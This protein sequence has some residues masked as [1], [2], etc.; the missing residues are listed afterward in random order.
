MID[1]TAAADTVQDRISVSNRQRCMDATADTDTPTDRRNVR[2]YLLESETV[3]EWRGLL[4][5]H[6]TSDRSAWPPPVDLHRLI[7][8]LHYAQSFHLLPRDA[9]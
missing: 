4:A 2:L 1:R 9:L 8:N 3:T 5:V 6:Q 7:R